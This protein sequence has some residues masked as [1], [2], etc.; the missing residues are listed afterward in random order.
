MASKRQRADEQQD[1]LIPPMQVARSIYGLALANQRHPGRPRRPG[2]LRAHR[3]PSSTG[4][5]AERTG[6]DRTRNLTIRATT[7][8]RM[9]G[10]SVAAS[11]LRGRYIELAYSDGTRVVLDEDATQIWATTPPGSSV[12]DTARPTS[13]DPC[14]GSRCA[15]A[16]VT[17]LHASCVA[18]GGL[19]FAFVGARAREID[20][21]GGVCTPKPRRPHR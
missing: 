17:C 3:H 20:P 18:I 12:E 11:R 14:S 8:T 16:G 19:A 15:C 13:W 2:D 4:R 7:A 1:R 9:A 21:C 6:R 10:P 5:P